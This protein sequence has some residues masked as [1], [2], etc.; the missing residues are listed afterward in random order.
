MSKILFYAA[1]FILLHLLVIIYI[2]NIPI[3]QIE[4]PL[5]ENPRDYYPYILYPL[6]GFDGAHYILIA[7]KGYGLLQLAFFPLYPLLMNAL[8]RLFNFNVLLS[9]LL[10]SWAS[11]ILGIFF[12]GKLAK[13]LM[14][15][16][17]N[18]MWTI[19][20]LLTFPTA[21]FY[22]AVYPESL[23]LFLS[24]ACLYFIARKNYLAASAFAILSS[25]T[26]IQGILLIIPFVFSILELNRL[27]VVNVISK[28]KKH[29]E[30]IL[31]VFSPIVGLLI[32]CSYLYQNYGDALAF[33][34]NQEDFGAS[35]TSQGIILLPQVIFRY[36][37][38]LTTSQESFQYWIALLEVSI[39]I[40]V[41]SV[42]LLNIFSLW[43]KNKIDFE[44]SLNLYSLGVLIL[45]T[46]TGT[47]SSIPR[48]ALL[49]FGFFIALSKIRNVVLKA[50]IAIIFGI[51]HVILFA[52]FIKGYFVS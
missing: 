48:Y 8:T 41:F 13:I 50:A 46:L 40:T 45:P 42:L 38:I 30:N 12:F 4:F 22:V 19:L 34:H 17:R 49:S 23:F 18:F 3:E 35:R 43:K 52:F 21:F 20:F 2:N 39:F 24:C 11:L 25:L 14:P 28:I 9:G 36:I 51:I 32:Y 29:R 33:Y 5:K 6:A 27:D 44:F 16:P 47:L 37:K 1:L 10:I 7:K 31:F 26:K 15:Q